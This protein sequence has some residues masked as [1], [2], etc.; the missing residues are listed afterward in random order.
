[1][2]E[3]TG[4]D[5]GTEIL[6][7]PEF[8]AEKDGVMEKFREG[9]LL[10]RVMDPPRISKGLDGLELDVQTWEDELDFMASK[11]GMVHTSTTL[12]MEGKEIALYHKPFGFIF[13]AEKVVVEHVALTDSGSSVS[14]SGELYANSTDL[15]TIEE[16]KDI[17]QKREGA[18]SMNEINA[19]IKSDAVVGLVIR[20]GVRSVSTLAGFEVAREIVE[21]ELGDLPVYEYDERTGEMSRYKSPNREELLN[22]LRPEVRP[23]YERYL[24]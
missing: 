8:V 24:I 13:D 9:E 23:V 2:G 6:T 11:E 1:M 20:R 19:T 15:K 16:L 14:K 21:R 7:R 3:T 10:I 12:V 18:E 22:G 5:A 17:Y 4:I